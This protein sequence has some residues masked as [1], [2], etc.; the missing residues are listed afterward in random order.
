MTHISLPY[1]NIKQLFYVLEGPT[2]GPA[3]IAPDLGFSLPFINE[4]GAG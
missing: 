3:S 2:C 1:N 4:L